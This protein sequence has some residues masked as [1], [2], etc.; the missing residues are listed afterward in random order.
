MPELFQTKSGNHFELNKMEADHITPWH[1]GGKTTAE[2]CQLLC[3]EVGENQE[4]KK[5][6][7]TFLCF[8]ETD[9]Q[10]M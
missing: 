5:C 1:E 8:S 4:N 9:G 7:W 10:D 6:L 2:N 3:I